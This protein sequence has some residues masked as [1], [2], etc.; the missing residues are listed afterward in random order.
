MHA[1]ADRDGALVRCL[2]L[3]DHPEQ[4]GLAGA[5]RAD[6]ADNAARRQLERQIVDQKPLAKPLGQALEI[7][8][9]LTEPLGHG[10]RDLRGLGLLLAGLLQ[11]LLVALVARLRFGLA[12][13]RRGRDP[14]LLA[15]QGTLMRRLFAA[16][17][18]ETLLLLRQPGGV[19]A[20]IGNAPA[21]VELENP[22]GDVVEEIAVM[23]DDQDRA[24]ILPQMAF[25]PR[26]RFGVE[27]V[28]RLV[29][30]AASRAGRAAAGT[31]RRGGAR[32]RR[33]L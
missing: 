33:V 24:G 23:G 11:E 1:V 16:L 28:G 9:V 2:L 26:Y 19:I 6:H 21:A 15:R 18:L 20:F 25:Q 32:R 4:R 10:N 22:P 7:D 13:L 29:Q 31:A 5:V 14:F 12:C 8:D 3:G 17:L 27:M 30:A